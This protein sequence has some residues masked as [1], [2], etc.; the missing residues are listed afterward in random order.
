MISAVFLTRILL[1]TSAVAL[2]VSP[3]VSLSGQSPAQTR[4]SGDAWSPAR[5]PD[6]K[7]DLQGIWDFRTATPLERPRELAGKAVFTREEAEDFER[8]NAERIANTVAVHPPSWLDYGMTLLDDLR[9]SLITDPAD[10]R[11][12]A[13]TAARRAAITERQAERR[14]KQ[15][16][17]EDMTLGERCLVFGAGPPILPGPYNNNLRIVQT[18]IAVVL[19]TEMIHDA[20][21][22]PVDG[23]PHLPPALQPWLGDSRGHWEHD[24]L[25]VETTNFSERTPFRG[26]DQHLRVVERL[27]LIDPNTLR[28]EFTIDDPTAFTRPW[29]A[30]FP[31]RRSTEQMYEYACHEGNYGLLDTLRGARFE[32]RNPSRKP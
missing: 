12:P 20:R 1:A 22:V 24:T 7:P 25:V 6:G 29:T 5:T 14:G 16:G 27:S 21:I 9:T 17:P 15:D 32:E 2:V 3:A 10:G 19:E 4:A 26:S 11:I 13:L 30:S 8:R 28:Y 23:R 18:G 31:M